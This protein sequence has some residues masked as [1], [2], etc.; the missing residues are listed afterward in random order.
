[1]PPGF[2]IKPPT[3]R[4]IVADH[5]RTCAV[6]TA[7]V[8]CWGWDNSLKASS[9]SPL[10]T[11]PRDLVMGDAPTICGFSPNEPVT[12]ADWQGGAAFSKGVNDCLP[13]TPVVDFTIDRDTTGQIVWASDDGV[14]V[15][16]PK[17]CTAAQL[18]AGVASSK[19]VEMQQGH[20]C[21]LDDKGAVAC[22]TL[23]GADVEVAL[24]DTFV[25][26]VTKF[27]EACGLTAAGKV[28]CWDNT[29]AEDVDPNDFPH[30]LSS[31]ADSPLVV[32]L[33]SDGADKLCA[34]FDDG[35][36]L[37]DSLFN[38]G[39]VDPGFELPEGE[40]VVEIALGDDHVCGIRA[41]NTVLCVP[42][43]CKSC[44]AAMA[45]PAGFEAAP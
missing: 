21:A 13:T 29:G 3:R 7:G 1:M 2:P 11:T 31:G 36:V 6:G 9:F 37:C 30:F 32:Q 41:D 22:W 15:V 33:A 28:R 14:H 19:R 40:R 26:V 23:A 5:Q 35:R 10:A 16:A 17:S 4:R 24:K 25:Q 45:A 27:N 38:H 34:L 44:D 43:G 8:V 39:S 12:C 20:L 42:Y 18:P